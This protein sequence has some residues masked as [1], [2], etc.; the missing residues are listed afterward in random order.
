[1]HLVHQG[2]MKITMFFCAGNFAETLGV[3]R[4][5]D[6]NGAGRRMPWTSAAFT[7]AVLGMIGVPPLA[8]AVTKQFIKEGA[9]VAGEHWVPWVLNA[10]ALLNA[11][12]F[13][14]IIWRL[15]FKPAPAR[16]PAEHRFGRWETHWMLLLPPVITAGD[17]HPRR[18]SRRHIVQSGRLGE[19]HRAPR[20]LGV[21]PARMK[22]RARVLAMRASVRTGRWSLSSHRD[23]R[24]VIAGG[25]RFPK[26]GELPRFLG[27]CA[28]DRGWHGGR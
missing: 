26:F 21:T 19:A 14:P 3:H 15:W 1:V 17:G 2:L 8:G 9:L 4:I 16:W 28:R 11:A 10:S 25:R 6:L 24:V 5:D 13:L 12:Y 7:V 18:S 27:G 22:S 23:R 20:I